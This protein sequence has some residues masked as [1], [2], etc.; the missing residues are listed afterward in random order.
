M[1]TTGRAILN[2][3]KSK[4]LDLVV[5]VL[6]LVQFAVLAAHGAERE[7]VLVQISFSSTYIGMP[8]WVT[9]DNPVLY[10]IHYPSSTTPSDFGCNTLEIKRAG[11]SI[12]PE[13]YPNQAWIGRHAAG[14]RH[15]I[16]QNRAFHY[17]SNIRC[18][19]RATIWF[20]IGD[21]RFASRMDILS[22]RS[23]SSSPTGHL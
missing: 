12:S 16:L 5:A 10:K 11:L 3:G 7:P 9:I 23:S 17:I 19:N 1:D 14:F 13:V 2:N 22:G 6:A 15:Q 21:M 8:I 4:S 20:G 18:P